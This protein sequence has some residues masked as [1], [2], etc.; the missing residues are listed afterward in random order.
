MR[1]A[2]GTAPSASNWEVEAPASAVVACTRKG[3]Y[4][5][6][7]SKRSKTP[8][9]GAHT[10]AGLPGQIIARERRGTSPGTGG[11]L[12]PR[13]SRAS[14]AAPSR[15]RARSRNSARAR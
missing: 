1:S 7:L 2:L 5:K 8:M 15:S 10:G 3:Y 6:F 4:Y 14:A 11:Y 13:P 12:A 9:C